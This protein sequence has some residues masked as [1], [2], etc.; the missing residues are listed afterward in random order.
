MWEREWWFYIYSPLRGCDVIFWLLYFAYD[1][2]W[3]FIY[4][5][6]LPFTFLLPLPFAF[7]FKIFSGIVLSYSAFQGATICP[8]AQSY[9]LV[10]TPPCCCLPA[11]AAHSCSFVLSPCCDN[12]PRNWNVLRIKQQNIGDLLEADFSGCYW[13]SW[14]QSLLKAS[15]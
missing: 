2:Y 14:F 5:F 1:K 11:S 6:V 10:L 4:F 3:D 7:P 15:S 8:E 9:C 13:E 12:I